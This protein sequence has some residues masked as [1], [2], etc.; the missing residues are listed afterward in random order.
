MLTDSLGQLVGW[1]DYSDRWSF[2]TQALRQI[3]A[4]GALQY[5]VQRFD[6][7]AEFEQAHPDWV[8]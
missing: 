8:G 2:N 7:E 5:E 6:D 1:L 4:A 3:A